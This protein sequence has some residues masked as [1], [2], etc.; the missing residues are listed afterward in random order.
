MLTLCSIATGLIWIAAGTLALAVVSHF[1]RK[2]LSVLD[3]GYDWVLF[4]SPRN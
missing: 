2:V 1:G 3:R 4:G